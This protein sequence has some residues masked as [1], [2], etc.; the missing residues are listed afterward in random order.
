[1]NLF[2]VGHSNYS[3]YDFLEMLKSHD[4]NCVVDVRSI[5]YSRYASQFNKENIKKFLN[6][7][8]ITY[9]Y[10]GDLLGARR[11][12]K[13]VYDEFLQVDFEKVIYSKNFLS[14]IERVKNGIS[15]NY[16]ISLMCAEKIPSNCHRSVLIGRYFESINYNVFH[17]L[18]KENKISQSEIEKILID[19][20]F[21]EINQ[22][23][24]CEN[25]DDKDL[26]K[27]A[28]KL[29]NKKIGYKVLD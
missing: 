23:S 9:V 21:S 2:T 16:K 22:I 19:E 28:Y 11:I 14:G 4:I 20:F 25:L 29:K 6:Q 3:E 24:F 15:K 1:M 12:E 26:I 27:M 5:P 17:I 18:D 8:N 7:N 10:M 13:E